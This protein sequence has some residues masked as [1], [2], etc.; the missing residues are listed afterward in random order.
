M[1]VK[2]KHLLFSAL[3]LLS[4]SAAWA[5]VTI[6]ETNFPDGNFRNWI[7]EQDYGSDGLLTDEEILSV[8][9]IILGERAVQSLKG[10]E[11]F[12]ALT[13]L[14]CSSNQLTSLDVSKNPKLVRLYCRNNQL[15]SLDVSGCTELETLHCNNNRLTSLDVS[16]CTV[17]GN[18]ECNNNRLSSLD[19][20]KNWRLNYLFCYQNQIKGT[21]MDALIEGL[22]TLTGNFKG[23]L[24]TIHYEREQ[25]VMTTTQ[26]AAA[27]AKGWKPCCTKNGT[28]WYEYAGVDPA[29]G[30]NNV[31]ASESDHTAPW[32]TI[33]GGK[34]QDKPTV[35]GIYIRG[36]RKVIVK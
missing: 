5:D 7:L 10:I 3:M 12:T 16:E 33:G 31:E 4:A 13:M 11:Y 30:V 24:W 9:G 21:A 34:L 14:E 26:V 20:S 35:A 25:N 1:H 22:P 19:V 32:Y 23:E 17:L 2:L 28:E 36:G 8:A 18:L 6:N 15:S 27:K 29:T